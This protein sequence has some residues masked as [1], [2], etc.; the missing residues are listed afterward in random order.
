MLKGHP[1]RIILGLANFFQNH[2]P[3][4]ID[5]LQRQ[6]CPQQQVPQRRQHLW[7]LTN[8]SIDKKM[9]I[10]IARRRIG[11]SPLVFHQLIELSRPQSP[12]PFEDQMLQKMGHAL[13]IGQFL[14]RSRLNPNIRNHRRTGA[15]LMDQGNA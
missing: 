5:L 10:I 14:G 6:L 8:G 11:D 15:K 4:P 9:G 7:K 12:R 3:L 13:L 2:F 1:I